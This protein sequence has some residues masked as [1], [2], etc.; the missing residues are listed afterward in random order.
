MSS[1]GTL[2]FSC[3]IGDQRIEF[4]ANWIF[5]L[6]TIS[7]LLVSNGLVL[8]NIYYFTYEKGLTTQDAETFFEK[9]SNP[10]EYTLA[11]FVVMRS[12]GCA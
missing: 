1:T 10:I 9:Q 7:E 5:S 6:E 11:I 3:P 4:N 8:K 2:Y 12:S